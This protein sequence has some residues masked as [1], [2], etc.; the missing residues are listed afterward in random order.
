MYF[1]NKKTYYDIWFIAHF[2]MYV[3]QKSRCKNTK[4]DM[5]YVNKINLYINLFIYSIYILY[6]LI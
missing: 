6:K 5:S 2:W 4:C 1:K 3:N